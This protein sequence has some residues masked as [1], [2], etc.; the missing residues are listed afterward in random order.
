VTRIVFLLAQ[1]GILYPVLR[2][3]PPSPD[4][5][6]EAGHFLRLKAVMEPRIQAHADDAE[7]LYYL[8]KA[9]GA[10]GN[11]DV[12]LKLADRAVALED[13]NSKYHVQLAAACGRLA[14]TA[15]L[16][17]QLGYARRAKKELDI[18][19]E[20]NPENQ[21]A[22]YGLTLFYFAA[23]SFLGGDKQKAQATAMSLTRQNPARGY[24]TQARLANERKDAAAE[25]D[26]YKKSIAAD[27]NFY[28][29]KVA[30]ASFYLTRDIS[31]A[32]RQASE[33]LAID[34]G[35]A[36]AWKILAQIHVATQCWDEL[37]TLLESA[38]QAVPDDL[39]CY[40]STAVALEQAGHFLGWAG[41]FLNVYMGAQ[42]EGNEPTL[43]EAEKA[44]RRVTSIA[45][46]A[47]IL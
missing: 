40:Y 46:R 16:M 17:K 13:T 31:A 37:L 20:L 8:S 34:P 25:E 14:Q 27:P 28:E 42:P 29:G 33:A 1:I 35:R 5:L 43:A 3:E 18:A 19:L 44:A 6:A 47:A 10:L 12:A 26:F 24:L 22:M 21:D 41:E 38:R 7:A 30:L 23:P 2:A 36:D 32:R 15:S 9:E 4:E 45:S 39:A 11:T